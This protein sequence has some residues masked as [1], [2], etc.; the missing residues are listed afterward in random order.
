[1]SV[2]LK[3]LVKDLNEYLQVDRIKDYCPNGLQVEGK[4]EIKKI[5]T[6]VTASQQLIDTAIEKGVDAIL[7]HHGYFWKGEN[8]CITGIKKQRIQA[9][10]KNDISLI[11]Y[12]LP[13]DCHEEV[14]NNIQLAQVLGFSVEGHLTGQGPSALGNVGRLHKPM[15]VQAFNA[16]LGECL[17]REPMHVGDPNDTI[18]TIA[19]CTGAA[20]SYLQ[21]AVD[22]GV[23]AFL[24]GEI[25][26][27]TVHL[28]R[29]TGIHFFSTGHH[30]TERYG[31]RTL[32]EHVQLKYGIEVE[33]IDID[34]PV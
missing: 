23:D 30:A 9:L 6:G 11:A 4:P 22:V 8:E 14:G 29:E 25:S 28:A 21:E 12:H 34:N 16:W 33:F 7:V 10:L 31:V 32:G 5:V 24:T 3:T 19:W 20:Q 2:A 26:E 18:E 27:P 17:Q 15:T 13:L 1:M